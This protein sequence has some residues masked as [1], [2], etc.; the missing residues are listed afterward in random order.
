[1]RRLL[2]IPM[3]AIACK[4]TS[5]SVDGDVDGEKLSAVSAFW[6]GPYVVITD[7]EFECIDMPWVRE[8]YETDDPNEVSTEASFKALQFTYESS[9][10]E[11]GKLSIRTKEAPAYAWFLEV[12]NE[13]ADA[14]Q[15]TSGSIDLTKEDDWVEGTFELTFGNAGEL[16][17]EF[18]IEKC[19]N[20]K[21]RKYE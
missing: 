8:D 21:K 16:E 17:G 20:L 14:T 13:E 11:E 18:V 9:E 4:S 5:V 10:V 7:A 2:L 19:A 1:M 3:L 6:G 12:E 15:A